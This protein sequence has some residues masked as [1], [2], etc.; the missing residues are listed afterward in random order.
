MPLPSIIKVN[1]MM[2]YPDRQLI[3]EYPQTFVLH[4]IMGAISFEKGQKEVAIEHFRKVIELRLIILM[5]INLGATLWIS[6]NM[7]KLS[8]I[9]KRPLNFNQ[10]MLKPIIT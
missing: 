10:T 7:K 8:L 2:F 1:L 6:V 3:K 9:L 4:N 5:L